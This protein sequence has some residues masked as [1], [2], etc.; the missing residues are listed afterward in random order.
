M[1]TS[2][3]GESPSK[4]PSRLWPAEKHDKQI[5]AVAFLID[6]SVYTQ[7]RRATNSRLISGFQAEASCA[8]REDFLGVSGVTTLTGK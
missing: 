4:L 6:R 2:R 3:S 5:R 7:N 1:E 8:L